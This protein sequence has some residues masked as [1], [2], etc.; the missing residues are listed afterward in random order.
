MENEKVEKM[1]QTVTY[2]LLYRIGSAEE[3]QE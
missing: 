3:E 1:T 2:V